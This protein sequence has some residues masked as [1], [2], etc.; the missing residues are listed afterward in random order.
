M[1]HSFSV[2]LLPGV[3]TI[4]ESHRIA[5]QQHDNL[6]G[7]YWA[8]IFLRSCGFNYT[9]EQVAQV[10]GS[11]LPTADPSTCIPKGTQSRQD[12]HLSLPI[13]EHIEQAGTSVIGLIR[14]IEQFSQGAY[15]LIPIQAQWTAARLEAI[16]ELCE[17]HPDWNIVPLCNLRTDHLWGAGL[18]IDQAIAYLNGESI[19]PP[20]ADWQ[21]GHFF[22]LA[23]TVKGNQRSLMLVCDTYPSLGWQGYHLQS[24][25]ALTQAL[26]RGDR[27]QGGIL[28][29]AAVQHQAEIEQKARSLHFTIAP[30]DNGSP[31][32]Q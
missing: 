9:S 23:G 16:T 24:V 18:A 22:V 30:W 27:N 20:V 4:V 2:S 15:C 3:V 25:E 19:D 29:F 1:Y 28:L 14:V 26:N 5:G 7:A 21:V 10:A 11:V 17:T 32:P 6:C 8:A 13:T 31:V 12:Y